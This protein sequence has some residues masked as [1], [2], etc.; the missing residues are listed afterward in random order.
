VH[1]GHS[2]QFRVDESSLVY[3]IETLVA[4]ARG[5]GAGVVHGTAV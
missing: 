5:V 2:P 4:F 3:G 1:P